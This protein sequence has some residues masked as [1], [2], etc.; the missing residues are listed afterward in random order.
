MTSVV[1]IIET[2]PWFAWIPIVAIIC[3]TIGGLV[4]TSITHRE[5]MAMIRQGIHPDAPNVKPYE[6]AEV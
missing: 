4:K 1:S 3:G 6:Q 2:M 5:R